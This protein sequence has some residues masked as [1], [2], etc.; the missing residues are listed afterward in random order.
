MVGKTGPQVLNRLGGE[1][2]S[3][4]YSE[5]PGGC[6]Q[7]V[8]CVGCT[9]R[10]AVNETRASGQPKRNV[11]A[12]AYVRTPDGQ[13]VKLLLRVT[14]EPVGGIVLLRMDE[15]STAAPDGAAIPQ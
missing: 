7:T 13:I 8:H 5:L 4:I 2:I 14:T 12:F 3:C 9:I 1:V 11:P 15:A 10:G 6:G